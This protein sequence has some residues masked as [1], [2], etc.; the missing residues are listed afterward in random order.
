VKGARSFATR[1]L[2]LAFCAVAVAGCGTPSATPVAQFKVAYSTFLAASA[3]FA[4]GLSTDLTSINNPANSPAALARAGDVYS[5]AITSFD[6]ALLAIPFTGKAKADAAVLVNDDLALIADIAL[7][8]N[9]PGTNLI[10]DNGRCVLALN[11]LDTDL[12]IPVPVTP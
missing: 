9:T 1:G 11:A 6:T 5:S 7:G 8:L 12:G 3:Q 4:G 10:N 2:T